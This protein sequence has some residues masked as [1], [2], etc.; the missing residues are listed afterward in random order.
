MCKWRLKTFPSKY[1][2]IYQADASIMHKRVQYFA[3]ID[4][5]ACNAIHPWYMSYQLEFEKSS[6]HEYEGHI[7]VLFLRRVQF[8]DLQQIRRSSLLH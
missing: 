3:E 1:R 7:K 8:L 2:A 4:G 5:L 6:I